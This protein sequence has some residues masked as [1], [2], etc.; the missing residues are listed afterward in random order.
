[1]KDLITKVENNVGCITLNRPNSLNAI[2]YEMLLEISRTLE[3][4]KELQIELV[5][6]DA[7]GDRAFCAGG[8]IADLYKNGLQKNYPYSQEFW[9]DEYRLNAKLSEYPAPIVSFMQGFTMGGGVGLG[10]HVSHRVVCESSK[11]AMPECGIGLIPDVGG[12]YIL[13]RAQDFVGEY[14]ATTGARMES[15]DA[16][17]YGFADHFVPEVY[18]RELKSL[19]IKTSNI[20]IIGRFTQEP[21]LG[22]IHKNKVTISQIFS[23]KGL[24]DIISSLRKN[25]SDFTKN[26]LES[27]SRNSPLSVCC[28]FEI[29]RRLKQNKDLNIR[30]ALSAEYQYTYR[31]VEH[32]DFLEG[33]RAQVIEKDRTPLWRHKTVMDVKESEVNKMLGNLGKNTLSWED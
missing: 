22:N 31:A 33:I 10:C 28:T 17:S 20:D 8:D 29:I 6:I 32:S 24:P 25:N 26:T 1:M 3:T 21:I 9:R 19:L 2:T 5:V 30:E 27:L 12:S 16:I 18:W 11:I 15:S 4:W 23:K 14:L 13:A 7:I